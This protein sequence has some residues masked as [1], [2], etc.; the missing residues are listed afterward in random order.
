MQFLWLATSQEQF[1]L[2]NKIIVPA[3]LKDGLKTWFMIIVP[4]FLDNPSA[5]EVSVWNSSNPKEY[6]IRIVDHEGKI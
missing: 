5:A 2:C 6:K 1:P 3:A 4:R